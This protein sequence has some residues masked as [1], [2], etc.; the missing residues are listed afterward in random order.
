MIRPVKCRATVL[1][2]LLVSL[3]MLAS[4]AVGPDYQPP[5]TDTS[6]DFAEIRGA[7]NIAQPE[8]KW[9]QGLQDELLNWLVGKA[10]DNNKDLRVAQAN[11][12]IV[13]A[14]L[15]EG[16]FEF[17]PIIPGQASAS[18]QQISQDTSS[19]GI[20]RRDTIYDASF[21]ATWELD[22]FGRVRR[23]VES[24][25]AEVD[26]AEYA[27]RNVFV[28]VTAEVGRAYMELRGAQY[29]LD[30]AG[31]N[32][33]N[34]HQT[35]QLTKDM[36][37]G[38]RGTDLDIARAQAQLESTLA[39]IPPLQGEIT[40]AINRISV[41]VGEQP[42][43]LRQQL[44]QAKSLPVLPAVIGVGDPASLLRR[45]PDIATAERQL[46]STTARIGVA[47][48]DLFPRVTLLGSYGS[49]SVSV[50]TIANTSAEIFSIGPSIT[51]AAFD[52]GRV[53]ARILAADA[54]A[55]AQLAT[56]EQ[57]VLTALEETENAFSN[58]TRARERMEH[59]EI[60]AKASDKAADL[61][62]LRYR[63]GVDS[64]LNV[65]DAESRLLTAQDALAQ[66]AT[67]SGVALV[68]IYKALGGGWQN[69]NLSPREN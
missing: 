29:R 54:R 42:Y 10:I 39:S 63:N 61:A 52:L 22:F 65:L 19:P 15:G 32:A 46:A 34:Q 55:E 23:S 3:F 21:D 41:L 69:Y 25:A 37:E 31:R 17:F 58:Y 13:R 9:W 57:T 49:R 12:R 28:T 50:S 2:L 48:A 44:Q 43:L 40:R 35:Y 24:L 1:L 36:L 7:L 16:I 4:C 33:E 59:L 30:V 62:R 27:L 67:E 45:R 51:W 11:V 20:Q 68:A 66:I 14:Q 47:T 38:G 60:A 56:Y 26:S 18:R 64:F 6:D 53:R 5:E 8:I